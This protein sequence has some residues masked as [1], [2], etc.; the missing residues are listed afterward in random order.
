MQTV[1]L[2]H[3]ALR[4]LPG[5]PLQVLRRWHY[6]RKLRAAGPAPEMEY[7]KYF[8][9]VG[10]TVLDLGANYGLYTRYRA[11]AV[12]PT[13]RVHAVEPVPGTFDILRSN[14]RRLRLD[15]ARVHNCAVSDRAGTVTMAVPHY[16]AGG[17]NLYEARVTDGLEA[18][19]HRT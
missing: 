12:G 10:S 13:G 6:A 8:A 9:P 5:R 7:F 11:E 2:K 17:E 16:R 1:S 15:A 3:F 4:F 14:V 19:P 18:G